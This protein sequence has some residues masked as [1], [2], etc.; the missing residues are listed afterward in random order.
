MFSFT[1]EYGQHEHEVSVPGRAYDP[2][3]PITCTACLNR[4]TIVTDAWQAELTR[5][6]KLPANFWDGYKRGFEK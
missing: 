1:D 5:R 6:H 3:A 2:K 4:L